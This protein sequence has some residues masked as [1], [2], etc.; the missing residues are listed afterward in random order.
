[1]EQ[2]SNCEKILKGI[3]VSSGIVHQPAFVLEK[4]DFEVSYYSIEPQKVKSE[5]Q[6]FRNAIE[7]TR[8]Q[9]LLIQNEITQKLGAYE[10]NIFDAHLLLLEDKSIYNA[11]LSCFQEHHC[12]IDYCFATVIRRFVKQFSS[13]EDSHLKERC[14]DLK[15]VA[16][17]VLQNL[18]GHSVDRLNDLFSKPRI[19]ISN[20]IDPSDAANLSR[21]KFVKAL[22]LESGSRTSHAVIMARSFGIPAVVGIPN[23]CQQIKANTP[24][25]I[26]GD[27]GLVFVNPSYETLSRYGQL[28]EQRLSLQRAFQN[29]SNK[30][31]CT[32][33]GFEI[34]LWLGSDTPIEST[35]L[36]DFGVQGIGLVR[37]EN[38][39]LRQEKFPTEDA[40]F[41]WYKAL[42]E[43]ANPHPVVIRTIDVGGDKIPKPL[44]N[45]ANE[46]N[47]FLGLRAIRFCLEHKDI[48]MQQLRAILR[49]SAFGNIKLLYPMITSVQELI[50]SN[51]LLDQ[52]KQEL[53]DAKIPFNES[54]PIG[55]MLE[56]PSATLIIDLLAPYCDFFSVGTND[57]IQYI[58]AVDRSNEKIAY[59]YESMHPAVLRSLQKIASD[60]ALVKK[61]VCVCGEIASDPTHI[62]FGLVLGLNSFCVH[63]DKLSELKYFIQHTS[64]KELQSLYPIL[65]FGTESKSNFAAMRKFYLKKLNEITKM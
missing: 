25:L 54:M 61:P 21:Q 10:A 2:G 58:L 65:N 6:R 13:I 48:F 5:L 37:T 59:L 12:N 44:S 64:M 20:E 50:Q 7:A 63:Q 60:C 8:R 45:L 17:R 52:C 47:P 9:I 35:Q 29:V 4:K 36:S 22:A 30:R 23:I 38:L 16:K 28:Q 24:V 53:R 34:E 31:V 42:A 46:A 32:H 26:D 62:A 55:A 56:T 39:F 27:E 49:A 15:D 14:I 41:K 3:G 1:M 18:M 33:D 51:E 57:L 19:L 43:K 40:Q 11:T